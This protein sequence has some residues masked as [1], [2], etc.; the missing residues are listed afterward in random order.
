MEWILD[1]S[2]IMVEI[3]RVFTIFIFGLLVLSH[4]VIQFPVCISISS[5]II[6]IDC[7][8]I[9]LP[10]ERICKCENL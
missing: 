4:N 1:M 6:D 7:I 2:F 9:W 5:Q 3:E 10:H 8:I